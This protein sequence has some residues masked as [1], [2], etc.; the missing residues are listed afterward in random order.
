MKKVYNYMKHF[1]VEQTSKKNL[2]LIFKWCIEN[3]IPKTKFFEPKQF[4]NSRKNHK[5][6]RL[7]YSIAEFAEK[8][9]NFPKISNL[10]PNQKKQEKIKIEKDFHLKIIKAN[11]LKKKNFQFPILLSYEK[12]LDEKEQEQE[13]EQEKKNEKETKKEKQENKINSPFNSQKRFDCNFNSL[14][15]LIEN[16]FINGL[17]KFDI[18]EINS[19]NKQICKGVLTFEISKLTIALERE[20]II[21][22]R[23]HQKPNIQMK[24]IISN[25]NNDQGQTKYI[26]IITIPNYILNSKHKNKHNNK[27]HLQKHNN[28]KL[29]TF[30]FLVSNQKRQIEIYQTFLMFNT[31][32]G[33]FVETHNFEGNIFGINFEVNSLAKRC[34]VQGTANFNI[35][36]YDHKELKYVEAFLRLD[37]NC[38]VISPNTK[39]TF[40]SLTIYWEDETNFEIYINKN[41]I[42]NFEIR[43]I[44]SLDLINMLWI[45]C[46]NSLYCKLIQRCIIEF[47]KK[48][49]IHKKQINKQKLDNHK[50]NEYHENNLFF[51]KNNF[52]NQNNIKNKNNI[53]TNEI[54]IQNKGFEYEKKKKN[55]KSK[56]FKEL[57]QEHIKHSNTLNIFETKKLKEKIYTN[58]PIKEE[59]IQFWSKLY[60]ED[61]HKIKITLKKNLNNNESN[62]RENNTNK[63]MDIQQVNYFGLFDLNKISPIFQSNLLLP[64][65]LSFAT[66]SQLFF[67][68]EKKTKFDQNI[69]HLIET[70]L[71]KGEKVFNINLLK[72]IS[73]SNSFKKVKNAIIS[74]TCILNKNSIIIKKKQNNR[75]NNSINN[76]NNNDMTIAT[77]NNASD[78]I[79]INKQYSINQKIFLHPQRLKLLLISFSINN[80]II[81]KFKNVMERDLFVNTFLCFQ[82]LFVSQQG[83]NKIKKKKFFRQNIKIL[84]P[85]KIYT[86]I[87][88]SATKESYFDYD[89]YINSYYLRKNK[90]P[91]ILNYNKTINPRIKQKKPNNNRHYNHGNTNNTKHDN[92]DFGNDYYKNLKNIKYSKTISKTMNKQLKPKSST[93]LIFDA[94]LFNS[95]EELIGK[96]KIKLFYDHFE[97]IF[98]TNLKINNMKRIYSQYSTIHANNIN[99]DPLFIRFVL[100]ENIFINL[101][102]ETKEKKQEFIFN[103]KKFKSI[104]LK[105]INEQIT[106]FSCIVIDGNSSRNKAKIVI[107]KNGFRV[108]TKLISL[109]LDYLPG[110]INFKLNDGYVRILFGNGCGNLNFLFSSQYHANQFIKTFLNQQNRF[111]SIANNG[112]I[113]KC[114]IINF[115]CYNNLMQNKNNNNN[116]SNN[117]NNNNVQKKNQKKNKK[118]KQFEKN[119]NY[120]IYL[121]KNYISYIK[122]NIN[123][124][125][126]VKSKFYRYSTENSK[127]FFLF[128]K[129]NLISIQLKELKKKL[130]FNFENINNKK[131]FIK[132][133]KFISLKSK[134]LK[135]PILFNKN[136]LNH[137][138]NKKINNNLENFDNYQISLHNFTNFKKTG[139]DGILSLQPTKII[140]TMSGRQKIIVSKLINFTIEFSIIKSKLLKLILKKTKNKKKALHRVY[141]ISFNNPIQKPNFIWKFGQYK[142]LIDPTYYISGIR[143][144]PTLSWGKPL[145]QQGIVQ[146]KLTRKYIK[147]IANSIQAILDYNKSEIFLNPNHPRECYFFFE[148]QLQIFI[149]FED[150]ILREEFLQMVNW[151]SIFGKS[152]KWDHFQNILENVKMY[153]QKKNKKSFS[154]INKTKNKFDDDNDNDNESDTSSVSISV[155]ASE[156]FDS[157]LDIDSNDINN[158]LNN[159]HGNINMNNKYD[160]D[161][162]DDHDGDDDDGDI[163]LIK[164]KKKNQILKDQHFQVIKLDNNFNEIQ[165]GN[166]IFQ[167]SKQTI[168][169]HEFSILNKPLFIKEIDELIL[170]TAGERKGIYRICNLENIDFIFLIESDIK[171]QEFISAFHKM[172]SLLQKMEDKQKRKRKKKLQEYYLK[173]G[174][175]D[176]NLTQDLNRDNTNHIENQKNN[177]VNIYTSNNNNIERNE[178]KKKEKIFLLPKK[179]EFEKNSQKDNGNKIQLENNSK[180]TDLDIDENV[181]STKLI[182]EAQIRVI[183]VQYL[184]RN[185]EIISQGSII[186]DLQKLIIILAGYLFKNEIILTDLDKIRI[187]FNREKQLLSRL[188]SNSNEY[189][190][191][192]FS[193]DEKIHFAQVVTTAKRKKFQKSKRNEKMKFQNFN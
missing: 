4:L 83:K 192:F 38:L 184:N 149:R 154:F 60:E 130:N 135:N 168:I 1:S 120:H 47:S 150:S 128:E 11:L 76:S 179:E 176:L 121:T 80:K 31:Y 125:N 45:K 136:L 94:S 71:K 183:D 84:S 193:N 32:Y 182:E 20:I 98:H 106:V 115:N 137:Y 119:N 59:S 142:K 153:Y 18:I 140:I 156:D 43:L 58:K 97:L 23:Y 85:Q 29:K 19:D 63:S 186:I 72:T 101:R 116:N 51:N 177:I 180:N 117:N 17:K 161:D 69:N 56:I 123:K 133:Y 164:L 40:E 66:L 167:F 24:K 39:Q 110:N 2:K 89:K 100:D 132:Y 28:S 185:E 126:I 173:K 152:K 187:M 73:I 91:F 9:K 46:N 34:L 169:F 171:S 92:D 3:G 62:R 165:N 79:I 163:K 95:I 107:Q 7:I 13:Q 12:K 77:P 175:K 48:Q 42:N 139:I 96:I 36:V 30:R 87:K 75:S 155:S 82:K 93:V 190:L 160:H 33:D 55:D 90:K 104:L 112:P 21:S 53:N 181:I 170:S 151:L 8:N 99:M 157:N 35:K 16:N 25:Y 52:K 6:I 57:N 172:K 61:H 131:K 141:L 65:S 22:R 37:H 26:L 67:R 127:L 109:Y 103:F 118:K 145:E 105:T 146:L 78:G 122:S 113:K 188:Y 49:L 50:S 54:K 27:N 114:D 88:H 41:K 178:N 129:S 148:K 144:Q 158:D 102:F 70:I 124:N 68:E 159:N 10:D 15:L 64:Y 189:N 138:G 191:K 143:Y 147:V 166:I 108:N 14:E 174:I 111:F 162:D 81:L 134:R 86:R 5:I 74:M 44:K